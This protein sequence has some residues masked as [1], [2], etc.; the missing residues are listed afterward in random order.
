MA[1]KFLVLI[2]IGILSCG[3]Y[4]QSNAT[5][6]PLKVRAIYPTGSEVQT[7]DQITIEF[8]QNIVS[9]GASIFIDDVVPVEVEPALDCE[10]NWVKLNTLKCD[11]QSDATL[12]VSTRYQVTVLPGIQTPRGKTLEQE[13]VH[14]FETITPAIWRASLVSWIS[15]TQPIITVWFNQDI[16]RDELHN[17]VFLFDEVSGRTIPTSIKRDDRQFRSTLNDDYFGT[18]REYLNADDFIRGRAVL[19]LPDELLSPSSKVSVVLASGV[20]GATGN[21]K[22]KERLVFDPSITTYADEF[23]LLGFGCHDVFEN[24]LYFEAGKP[25]IPHCSISSPIIL[26]F[27]SRFAESEIFDYVQTQPSTSL[28]D[29]S[30]YRNWYT[31]NLEGFEGIHYTVK[32]EFAPNETYQFVVAPEPPQVALE[33]IYPSVLPVYDGFGRPLVGLNEFAIRTSRLAPKVSLEATT[34]VAATHTRFDPKMYL[35]NVDDITINYDTIDLHGVRKDQTFTRPSPDQNDVEEIQFLGLR[36]ALDSSSGVMRGKIV[37]KPRFAGTVDQLVENFF[38]QVTPYSVFYKLGEYR[39]V[40]WV[41][42]LQT[43]EPVANATVDFYESTMADFFEPQAKIYSGSTDG[44]GLLVLPGFET[45]DPG[46]DRAISYFVRINKDEDL[47]FLPLSYSYLLQRPYRIDFDEDVDHWATTGQKLYRRGDTVQ[48][49]GY[50]RR[51][52]DEQR[53]IPKAGH[54]GLC[55]D[56]PEDR[57]YEIDSLSL[58]EFGAYHAEF[59][60]NDRTTLGEYQLILVYDPLKPLSTVCSH[61][62]YKARRSRTEGIR[63]ANG[64]E[65]EVF[66]FKTNPIRVNQK[67]NATRYERGE[68][69]TITTDAKLHAGGPYANAKGQIVVEISPEQ[70]PIDLV[71]TDLWKF[72]S[73]TYEESSVAWYGER[74]AEDK[75]ELDAF[76]ENTYVIESLDSGIYYGELVSETA[77]ASDRGKHVA[78]RASAIYYGV[79]QFVGIQRPDRYDMYSVGYHQEVHVNKPWPINVLVVS[80]DQKIIAEKVVRVTVYEG[81]EQKTGYREYEWNE[82]FDCEIISQPQKASCEFTPTAET[83]YRIEAEIVDSKGYS[84]LS[85]IQIEA[86]D[87]IHGWLD[88]PKP[89]E[90]VELELT[91]NNS[92]VEVGDLIQCAVE[93]HF[94]SSPILVTVERSGVLDEWLVRLD[95]VNSV[96]EFEVFETYAPHFR[97]SVLSTVPRTTEGHVGN[98]YQGDFYQIATAEFEIEDP[99][100][101]PFT[102][103]VAT[104][105]ETYSPRDTVKLSIT[106]ESPYGRSIPVEYA[107]AVVDEAL[108]DLSGGGEDYYDPTKKIWDIDV[109]GVQTYGLIEKLMNTSR[110]IT[111]TKT[112]FRDRGGIMYSMVGPYEDPHLNEKLANSETRR[113]DRLIAY[114]KPSVIAT[115]ERTNLEFELPDNLTSWKVMVMAVSINDRFGFGSTTFGSIKDTEIRA[116][117]PNVVTEGD[118]FHIGAS[119]Y[120][121]ANRHR[122]LTVEL[123]AT[124]QLSTEGENSYRERLRFA[125]KERKLVTIFVEADYSPI[126]LHNYQ[127]F[128]EISVVASAGDRRDM[129]ALAMNIPVRSSRFPVSSV[130]YGTLEGDLTSIPFEVP[131]QLVDQNGELTFSLATDER[132]NLDGVFRYIRDYRYPCWEQRLTRALLAMQY[133]RIEDK[134]GEHGIQW[135]DAEEII[136]TVLDEAISYQAPNGGMAFFEPTDANVSP[137]L[138][139]YTLIAFAW[140]AEA[141]HDIPQS[142][143]HDLAGFLRDYMTWDSKDLDYRTPNEEK[144]LLSHFQ[145]TVGAVVLHALATTGELSERELIAHSEH[146]EQMDLFGLSQYLLAT[147]EID[148]KLQQIDE[149][150]TR[151]MNHRSLV[152]GVVEFIEYVPLSSG[153]RLLHSDTRSLCSILESLTKL[154]EFSLPGLDLGELKELANSVRY[155]RNSLPHWMSTQDNVFCTQAMLKFSDFMSSQVGEFVATADLSSQNLGTTTRIADGWQFNL[156]TTRLQ[157]RYSLL[158][159]MLGTHGTIGISRQGKGT[160]FYNVELSYLTTAAENLNRYSGF[161]IHREYVVYRNQ[162][163]HILQ[164]GDHVKKGEIVLVNL[165]LNNRFDRYFVVVDDTVPGGLE[166]VNY[167]LGTASRFDASRG[168]QYVL[169]TSQ[170]FEGFED[171]SP[172]RWAFSYHELGLQNVRYFAERIS[173]G[174][175]HLQ[176]VGQVIAPG[177]FTAIPTHVEEM[178]R[179]VMFGKSEPWTLFVKDN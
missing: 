76:G 100:V 25:D 104:D 71:D 37:S 81:S 143:K 155:V 120:N 147:L 21:L 62:G 130:V 61:V 89:K 158:P 83:Q 92:K 43:G 74:M 72:S 125:P 52:Y 30:G 41:L 84:H 34:L 152:D 3:L 118:K 22:S 116:V 13:Y 170:W 24:V 17:K 14:V 114:W 109:N 145:A 161:E 126:D 157:K 20:A 159:E 101:I 56:G 154:S 79:D 75:I 108:L 60:L 40:A 49:K 19:L 110:T 137:Y 39:S 82:V 94:D 156:E 2:V 80:K 70:P 46:W 7:T 162:E 129:D 128:G 54:F 88:E 6:K 119:I 26:T 173:R 172:G 132:V 105:R 36:D 23:R 91:C 136:T 123:H 45:F 139:A 31:P 117:A 67:L 5:D 160:A 103:S 115:G 106:S 168:R 150:L 153:I 93:N 44:N 175:Y 32:G 85:R 179:P 134:G 38:A 29:D 42:D 96:L 9:L 102:F 174:R 164:P 144:E 90:F 176:W 98:F 10:W 66:E 121:R 8:N 124:G 135:S 73:G 171:A 169:P 1:M 178:Y 48:V 140:L 35:Q 122:T 111:K 138:S 86:I 57:T 127:N 163:A 166:P 146:L 77:V 47:A 68:S 12:E 97:L 149:I 28:V 55:V 142:I 87:D 4:A 69:L 141:G 50:V 133:L 18:E 112:S 107:I 78:T 99:R 131:K 27:S 11:L 15:P 177:E 151:I 59:K 95:D 113:V 51:K 65:F 53:V 16:E 148:P 167:E 33:D 58:N 63:I 64:G 165:Y